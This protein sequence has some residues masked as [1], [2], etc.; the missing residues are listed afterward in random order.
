M[1]CTS[2]QKLLDNGFSLPD[3]MDVAENEKSAAAFSEIRKKLGEGENIADVFPPFCPPVY[4]GYF[5]GFIRYLSF[6][7]SLTVSVMIADEEEKRKAELIKGLLYPVLM[8]AGVMAGMLMFGMIVMPQMLSLTGSFG[9]DPSG[10]RI[11]QKG[12]MLLSAAGLVIMAA[13]GL[14]VLYFLQPARIRNTYSF[15]AKRFPES[16]LTQYA[17]AEFIR[18]YLSFMRVNPSTY[19]CMN[20]LKHMKDKPLVS[21]IAKVLDVRLLKGE[22]FESALQ[23]PYIEKALLRFFRIA[24]HASDTEA[25]LEGY[26]A[27]VEERRNRQIRRLTVLIQL[28]AYSLIGIVIITVYRILMIP[29][30]MMR[31]I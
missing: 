22:S 6:S 20:V 24:V 13:G 12:A 25:M 21:L 5:A 9:I 1:T 26:L 27:M 31:S 23:T 28:A 10:Y 14:L 30:A 4:R 18:F 2:L 11:L 17:S 29:M 3:A 7:D 19:E 15:M 16:L 8:A